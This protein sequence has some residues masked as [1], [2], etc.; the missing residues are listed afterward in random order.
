M[1]AIHRQA[2]AAKIAIA[3]ASDRPQSTER[4]DEAS[5]VLKRGLAVA[6]LVVAARVTRDAAIRALTDSGTLAETGLDLLYFS[7]AD[8]ICWCV[9]SS[10]RD[11]D[12]HAQ[13]S[14]PQESAFGRTVGEMA[15][16]PECQKGLLGKALS[17]PRVRVTLLLASSNMWPLSHALT[18]QLRQLVDRLNRPHTVVF[19]RLFDELQAYRWAQDDEA[20]A[21][22]VDLTAHS[23]ALREGSARF[24]RGSTKPDMV[25]ILV[26]LLLM[27]AMVGWGTAFL[28]W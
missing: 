21:V 14:G 27:L 17:D 28:F 19:V 23:S 18:E 12:D 15:R 1:S 24:A 7:E 16:R 9:F 13:I 22:D 25:G 6:A 10:W 20:F 5:D 2:I 11:D 8:H 4:T 26:S 3:A